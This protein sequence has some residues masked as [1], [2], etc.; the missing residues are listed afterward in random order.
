MTFLCRQCGSCCMYLGDYIVIDEE[1]GPFTF[2]CSSVST[3]TPFTAEVDADKRHL[4]L[5][6]TWIDA[7]PAQGNRS[8]RSPGPSR[9]ILMTRRFGQHMTMPCGE[10]V[11]SIRVQKSSSGNLLRIAG[12]GSHDRQHCHSGA[13][14]RSGGSLVPG[15]FD[16]VIQQDNRQAE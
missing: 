9:S 15:F 11:R 16:L 8:G 12:T 5:D 6:R 2:A 10:S 14:S 3:G 13:G 7:H 1:C 4:F